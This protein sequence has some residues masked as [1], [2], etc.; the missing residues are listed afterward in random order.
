MG[1]QHTHCI[2]LIPNHPQDTEGRKEDR[3]R[4]KDGSTGQVWVTTLTVLAQAGMATTA[5][6][7][8][9]GK[10][11]S[12][13]LTF[14][15]LVANPKKLLYTVANPARG[16]RNREIMTINVSIYI[17]YSPYSTCKSLGDSCLEPE[18]PQGRTK[19]R[20]SQSKRAHA[21]SFA[22]VD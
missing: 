12:L 10:F 13:F 4:G 7:K 16:L 15:V 3:G 9:H 11:F 21:G 19:K 22:I 17:F 14:S 5:R 6:K 2:L 18:G 20:I 8:M 1:W